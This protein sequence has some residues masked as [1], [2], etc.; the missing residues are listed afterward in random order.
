[1]L[2]SISSPSPDQE[3]NPESTLSRGTSVISSSSSSSSILTAPVP[4]RNY[5][6]S[7]SRSS[8]PN[9]GSPSRPPPWLS[10][11]FRRGSTDPSAEQAPPAKTTPSPDPSIGLRHRMSSPNDFEFGEELGGGSWS[12]VHFGLVTLHCSLL[13]MHSFLRS[14]KLYIHPRRSDMP[15]RF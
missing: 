12:T 4:I 9:Y 3:S 7:G 11:H 1:M 13:L 15:S 5:V 14:W 6:A 10:R 2:V 8:S